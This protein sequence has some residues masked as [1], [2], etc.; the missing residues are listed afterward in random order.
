[1]VSSICF[2]IKFS[3]ISL[4]SWSMKFNV[5]LN[6]T[7][8]KSGIDRSQEFTYPWNCDIHFIHENWYP[9]IMSETNN[10][11][12][13]Q[14]SISPLVFS[15]YLVME[16]RTDVIFSSI[17]RIITEEVVLLVPGNVSPINSY[18]FMSITTPRLFMDGPGNVHHFV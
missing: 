15:L 6:E 5:H 16:D 12:F 4:L 10:T 14:N 17:G 18:G 7:I 9:W 13:V 3:L 11:Q 1:M 2:E 8:I